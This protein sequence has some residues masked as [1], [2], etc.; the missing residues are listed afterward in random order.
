[1]ERLKDFRPEL[2]E[3]NIILG[4]VLNGGYFEEM[5]EELER[6]YGRRWEKEWK[7]RRKV[8]K[9]GWDELKNKGRKGDSKLR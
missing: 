2:W 1:M 7:I 3:T 8:H 5:E 6:R 4:T 9:N